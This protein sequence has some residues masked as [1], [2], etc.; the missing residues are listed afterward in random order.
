M[1]LAIGGIVSLGGAPGSG[2]SSGSSGSGIVV[3]NPG[4]NVGPSVLFQGV[5]GVTVTSPAANTVL[6]N[7]AGASGTASTVTKY[8][9][10]FAGITS[11]LFNHNLNTLDVIVQVYSS[12]IIRRQMIPD[13]IIVEHYNAV[14]VVFN[15]PTTG[16]VVII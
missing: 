5:N 16:Y 2:T 11:G 7:G 13:K 4:T 8:S 1:G 10:Q 9:A 14:S 6:I 12:G 3:I 15:F